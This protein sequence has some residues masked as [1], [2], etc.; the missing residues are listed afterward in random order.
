MRA[1]IAAGALRAGARLPSA[2]EL[3]ASL[4]VNLHTVLHAKENAS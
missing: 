2:R 1:D 4:G 3:A